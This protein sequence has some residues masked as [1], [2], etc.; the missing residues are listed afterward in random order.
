MVEVCLRRAKVGPEMEPPIVSQQDRATYARHLAARSAQ[1]VESSATMSLEAARTSLAGSGKD[2]LLQTVKAA[3]EKLDRATDAGHAERRALVQMVPDLVGKVA[4][5]G[6][7]EFDMSERMALEALVRINDRPTYRVIGGTID[8]NDPLYGEWGGLLAL[9]VGLEPWAAAVGR[10]NLDGWHVGTGY[11][12]APGRV[13]TNRHVLEACVDEIFG[14]AGSEWSFG[15][16][17]VTIDFSETGD[18][19]DRFDLTSVL[20]TGTDP[21]RGIE[22]LAHLDMAVF[23]MAA[24]MTGVTD[25]RRPL[26][27]SRNLD[28]HA[29]LMVIGYPAA[30]GTSALVDPN[31]GL[32]STAIA[33][34]LKTLFGT[35]YGRKYVSPGR[36]MGQPGAF[37]A[38]VESWVISH[39]CTTLG[40]NSGSAVIQLTAN[41][42]VAALHFSGAP[43]SSN[44]AHFLSRV[45]TSR[46]GPI[47]AATWV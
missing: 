29:D 11:L 34:R 6:P 40:G 9:V 30:P 39:D 42:G 32:V 4:L 47:A 46:F 19:S 13:M 38:D 8:D 1:G 17:A 23:G 26:S 22:N 7:A 24:G 33:Q 21:V 18:G 25:T 35:D 37:A 41:P 43:L 16:G 12:I 15:R 10:I 45:D 27:L 44:K 20:Q 36:V 14:P 5:P 3:V 28:P 31:T 2:R